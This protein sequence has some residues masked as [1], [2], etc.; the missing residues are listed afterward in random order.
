MGNLPIPQKTEEIDASGGLSHNQ[1]V[2]YLEIEYLASKERLS[3]MVN[4]NNC[5]NG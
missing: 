4:H 1:V 2:S 5:L 3:H